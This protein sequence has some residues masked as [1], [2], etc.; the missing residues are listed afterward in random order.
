MCEFH[1]SFLSKKSGGNTK[2]LFTDTDILTNNTE[3]NDVLEG[4]HI[5]KTNLI[6]KI[7]HKNSSSLMK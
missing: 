6:P 5:F 7:A 4:F 1:Y 2:W 3:M